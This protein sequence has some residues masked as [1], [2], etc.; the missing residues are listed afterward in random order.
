MLGAGGAHGGIS[1][2]VSGPGGAEL[3]QGHF[4]QLAA[5]EVGLKGQVVVV[6][7]KGGLVVGLRGH[8]A[9][10]DHSLVTIDAGRRPAGRL[11]ISRAMMNSMTLS[12]LLHRPR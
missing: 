1:G 2:F 4:K 7:D 5:F 12:R 9:H 10:H 3:A 8:G 11:L 6:P